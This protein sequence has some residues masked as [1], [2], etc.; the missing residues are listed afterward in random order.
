MSDA[1][2][3]IQIDPSNIWKTEFINIDSTFVSNVMVQGDC[4]TP[5]TFQR[6]MTLIFQDIIGKYVH[7]YIDGI[8]IFSDT[9][10]DHEHHI[11][12]VFDRHR[13]Q[14]FFLKAEKCKL[15]AKVMDCLGHLI[16]DQGTSLD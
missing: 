15:F 2:E 14:T 4:N 9:L 13:K 12:D 10:E 7:V 11:R 5:A 6:V 1:F 3:Q 8:F 16:D